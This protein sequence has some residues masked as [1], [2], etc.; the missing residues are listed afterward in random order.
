MDGSR[1]ERRKDRNWNFLHFMHA[2]IFRGR[3]W[4]Y[5]R[6]QNAY[7]WRKCINFYYSK[8]W[9]ATRI[10]FSIS[11]SH[12]FFF[13]IHLNGISTDSFF[14]LLEYFMPS[15][16]LL[17]SVL[18]H[19][20]WMREIPVELYY[21]KNILRLV[22]HREKQLS[23][24]LF[25]FSFLS[26]YS[27]EGWR[28]ITAESGKFGISSSLHT[29]SRK[30]EEKKFLFLFHKIFIEMFRWSWMVLF[31]L[32]FFFTSLSPQKSKKSEWER[33]R[34]DGRIFRTL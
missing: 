4:W 9:N 24:C 27:Q 33:R 5:S 3:W 13:G 26:P 25:F 6:Q 19:M 2:K 1:T 31:F 30:K 28:S 34:M 17:S 32:L 12:F 16:S 14:L 29:K 11:F 7:I 18:I 21:W 20:K 8:V 15:T 23:Y 10:F 22:Y